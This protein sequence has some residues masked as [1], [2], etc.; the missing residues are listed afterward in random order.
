MGEGDTLDIRILNY[1]VQSA[2]TLYTVLGGG[3]LEYPLI[4]E[5]LVV[6]GLT[7]DEID[8]RV[9]AELK[10]RE[11]FEE[12]QV[13]VS[14]RE[15]VSHTA[16]INGL[17]ENP[18][19]KVM[20]REALPL[21]V[22]LAEAAPRPEAGQVVI[23]SP[24]TNTTRTID[25][26]DASAGN[27]LVNA[28]DVLRVSVRPPQFFYIGGEVGAPGQKNFHAGLTLTQAVLAS[29]GATRN[30]N[31]RV[32]VSRQGADGRLVPTEYNLKEIEAGRIPDPPLQSGDRVEIGRK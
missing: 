13:V 28:G 26:A 25:L 27:T 1:E 22:L 20:R 18:G 7:T 4:G 19:V 11:V 24:T 15:Y 14:V 32:R 6:S 5:P 2:S 10:R 23:T 31:G 21:Y 3:L 12:P 17:V 16:T 30:T 8:L 9:T 29:G